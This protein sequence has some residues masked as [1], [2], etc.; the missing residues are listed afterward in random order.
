MSTIDLSNRVAIQAAA[1]AAELRKS[2]LTSFGTT[3]LSEI[4][5]A[6][7]AARYIETLPTIKVIDWIGLQNSSPIYA[8][9]ESASRHLESANRSF[10]GSQIELDVLARA[11]DT[12]KFSVAQV[13]IDLSQL[14]GR[15][16]RLLAPT[17]LGPVAAFGRF[18]EGT[19]SR[20]EDSENEEERTALLVS[21]DLAEHELDLSIESVEEIATK[22]VGRKKR[23][24][25]RSHSLLRVQQQELL[26]APHLSAVLD[27]EG[28]DEVAPSARL[29]KLAHSIGQKLVDVNRTSRMHGGGD[30]FT[31]TNSF[32]EAVNNFRWIAATN[33]ASFGILL[34]ALYVMVYES[35]GNQKLRYSGFLDNETMGI[36]WT[37]KH[38]RNKWLRHDVEH[39]K[40]SD[41]RVSYRN[42][43]EALGAL[44]FAGLPR[45]E[46][47]FR[48]IHERLLT[49]VDA[50][51][52]I[53]LA[54]VEQNSNAN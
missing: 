19:V 38:L 7:E 28:I 6:V 5:R 50:F 35:A 46:E 17:F 14:G 39:G 37:I 4:T 27:F 42:L 40:E 26:I 12:M 24:L 16:S 31:P 32:I 54:A 41:I 44:G 30:I 49:K 47:D 48:L 51:L 45:T 9:L 11:V 52:T 10:I 15:Q 18:A 29:F 13:A 20:I 34:D 25:R 33:R 21:L 1:R 3:N 36:I 23:R 2:L 43:N 8:A 22:P 53:L